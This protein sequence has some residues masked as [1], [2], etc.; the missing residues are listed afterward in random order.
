MTH[1]HS[2][3]LSSRIDKEHR[4]DLV[5]PIARGSTVPGTAQARTCGVAG[6]ASREE[7]DSGEEQECRGSRGD[8]GRAAARGLGGAADPGGLGGVGPVVVRER[9]VGPSAAGVEEAAA[10]LPVLRHE[11]EAVLGLLVLGHHHGRGGGRRRRGFS[12]I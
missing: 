10:G 5:K 8:G 6:E 11:P 3:S 12:A 1:T 7:E 9:V 2:L 4:A